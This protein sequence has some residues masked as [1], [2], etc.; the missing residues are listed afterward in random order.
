MFR[1][2]RPPSRRPLGAGC[3]SSP[4]ATS[5]PSKFISF[6]RH[7]FRTLECA[8]L[9]GTERHFSRK[10]S[11]PKASTSGRKRANAGS[12]AQWISPSLPEIE[13]IGGG[14]PHT[15][16]PKSE[17]V[18][19]GQD[20]SCTTLSCST[21]GSSTPFTPHP[22]PQNHV[23]GQPF[24]PGTLPWISNWGNYRTSERIHKPG[25]CWPTQQPMQS[26]AENLKRKLQ[27]QC[28]KFQLFRQ[29]PWFSRF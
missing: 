6:R 10:L 25:T 27:F 5:A 28:Q 23:S 15:P 18:G 8:R 22:P 20:L 11:S 14:A 26:G 24:L 1:C 2:G 7:V 21:E 16:P 17:P 3:V 9:R 19:G 4:P 13:L 12:P 29:S